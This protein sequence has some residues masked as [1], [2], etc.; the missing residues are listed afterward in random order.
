MTKAVKRA[1]GEKDSLFGSQTSTKIAVTATTIEDSYTVIFTNY[2]GPDRVR[3]CYIRPENIDDEML[4]W[5]I[6]FKSYKGY[7]DGGLGGHNCPV[8]L[9]LWEQDR[10][11]SR[12]LKQPDCIV[13]VG[14]GSPF[15]QEATNTTSSSW[16][17]QLFLPRMFR[18]YMTFFDCQ[19]TWIQVLNSTTL[20]NQAQFHRLNLHFN[21]TGPHLDNVKSMPALKEQVLR[22]SASNKTDLIRCADNILAS[23]FYLE[24]EDLPVFQQGRFSCKGN[25]LCRLDAGSRA[26]H[27]LVVRLNDRQARFYLDEQSYVAS[28]NP[29]AFDRIQAGRAYSIPVEFQVFSINEQ[30]D[31]KVDRL[32]Q[33]ARSISNFPYNITDLVID[34]G[35]HLVFGR[36]DHKRQARPLEN[37]SKRRRYN[38]SA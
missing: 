2:N 29:D 21:S 25:I 20:N 15:I 30:L 32:T 22:D 34:Q 7:H 24:L 37:K 26:L 10:I 13:S 8:N 19:K 14:T 17:A 27:S 28:M 18:S 6:F 4:V 23:L 35:L 3:Y 36:P 16:F 11:W 12:K 33:R 9:A 5:E 38:Q 1:Y 31:F